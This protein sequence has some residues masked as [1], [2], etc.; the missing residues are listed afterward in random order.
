MQGVFITFEGN[1]G[2]G[3]STVIEKI[4]EEL[5]NNG[6]KV[7]LTREPG[8]IKIS[9]QIRQII[10]DKNNSEMDSRT[11]ALLYAA[12]RRQHVFEKIKPALEQGYIVLCDR[13]IDSSLAYQGYARGIGIDEVY[14]LNL[15]ATGGLLPD[16]TIYIEINPEVGFSRMK[17]NRREL[18]RLE[19]ESI[20]FHKAVHEGYQLI[21]KRFKDRIVTINGEKT[22]QDVIGEAKEV[23]LDFINRK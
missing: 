3:K 21:A 7:I 19:L 13:F 9:E 15:F 14:N 10:L 5:K 18:D 12:S 4:A 23:V 1:D 17:K 2:S 20:S 8:G 22:P 11:E 16:L 6:H